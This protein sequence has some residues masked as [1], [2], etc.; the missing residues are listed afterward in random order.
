MYCTKEYLF[1]SKDPVQNSCDFDNDALQELTS[2]LEEARRNAEIVE[3]QLHQKGQTLNALEVR[4]VQANDLRNSRRGSEKDEDL[5]RLVTSW[6]ARLAST[7]EQLREVVREN[8]AELRRL[9]NDH[10]TYVA[11]RVSFI[12]MKVKERCLCGCL[13]V[14]ITRGETKS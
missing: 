2:E 12:N 13:G 14:V 7:E 9:R 3:E 8:L 6:Q 11:S 10:F 5:S 1:G 4:L